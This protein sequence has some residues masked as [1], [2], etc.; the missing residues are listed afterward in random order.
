M[1]P[2]SSPGPLGPGA[3]EVWVCRSY[4]GRLAYSMLFGLPI[5]D[6]RPQ[7]APTT[8]TG[9]LRRGGVPPPANY[10]PAP[11]AACARRVFIVQ[12]AGPS[13]DCPASGS[14]AERKAIPLPPAPALRNSPPGSVPRNGVRGKAD[15]EDWAAGRRSDCGVPRRSFGSFPI[16][17]K[18][19]PPSSSH[20]KETKSPVTLFVYFFP[21]K[22][23]IFSLQAG[24]IVI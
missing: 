22:W 13:L 3:V 14:G 17:R 2:T 7:A 11:T 6:G 23:E 24:K 19:T 18:G 9:P 16:V 1:S 21:K 5:N 8:R 12:L 10:V 4:R 20:R 15:M